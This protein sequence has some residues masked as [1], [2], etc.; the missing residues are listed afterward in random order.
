MSRSP[1]G[2]A[3]LLRAQQALEL[4]GPALEVAARM[5]GLTV[6]VL[7]AAATRPETSV[8]VG[9]TEE[10]PSGLG[11]AILYI[12]PEEGNSTNVRWLE[13]VGQSSPKPPLPSIKD[14]LTPSRKQHLRSDR[15]FRSLL[16]PRVASELVLTAACTR[17]PVSE[18]DVETAVEIL[19]S[20]RPLLELPWLHSL[21]LGR[22][23][24]VLMDVGESMEPFV[25][26]Q[27][28]FLGDIKK[29]MGGGAHILFFADDPL[30]GAGPT[31]RRSDWRPYEL[32]PA[33]QPVIVLSDLGCGI[34]RREAAKQAW[35]SLGLHLRRRDSRVL[36]L[37][38]TQLQRIPGNLRRLMELVVW[39]R[40]TTRARTASLYLTMT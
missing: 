33:G 27:M 39:D 40:S 13:P 26:D 10:P 38:P 34:P 9:Q 5:F 22:G 31:R 4:E 21:S 12:S 37:A 25:R 36:V 23:V 11:P 29:L 6:A 30:L 24:Q 20:Q 3:D 35:N 2:I 14:P 32:P 16:D 7:P 17:T 1:V 8:P 28:E 19:S 15:P 18:I